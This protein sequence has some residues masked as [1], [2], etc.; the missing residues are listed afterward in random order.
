MKK[1]T[2]FVMTAS[3][4]TSAFID[5]APVVSAHAMSKTAVEQSVPQGPTT[6]LNTIYELAHKG[7]MPY[8]AKGLK[9][10][11]QT[12][13]DVHHKLEIHIQKQLKAALICI[14]LKWGIRDLLF[15][16]MQ[17]GKIDE[18]RYF[19]TNVEKK[20]ISAE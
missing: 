15:I 5:S 7:Q 2:A 6:A 3:I 19:G 12:K 16:M 9:I 13:K 17:K 11:V 18:I 8:Y 14:M 10:G 4:A 1:T 20:R